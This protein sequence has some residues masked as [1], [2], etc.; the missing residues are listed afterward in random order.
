M[1]I[2]RTFEPG[3]LVFAFSET[4]GDQAPNQKVKIKWSGPYI[5]IHRINSAMVMIGTMPTKRAQYKAKNF[6]IHARKL[7]LHQRWGE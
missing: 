5:F 4:R 6:V 1:G 3:D 7:L 2:S